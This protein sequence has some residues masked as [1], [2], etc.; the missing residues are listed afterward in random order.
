[1]PQLDDSAVQAFH[2]VGNLLLAFLLVWVYFAFSQFLIIWSG[3]LPEEAVWYHNRLAGGWQWFAPAIVVGHFV[4]PFAL[5]LSR[6]VKRA[7]RRLAVVAG[8]LLLMRFVELYW[9]TMPAFSPRRITAHWLDL[10]APAAIG[11]VWL[12]VFALL[13]SRRLRHEVEGASSHD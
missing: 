4:I 6:D 9:S 8:G 12:A 5:L 11:G 13:L 7:P 1:V 2:D 3:D 10:A